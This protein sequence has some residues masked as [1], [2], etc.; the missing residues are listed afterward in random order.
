VF[1]YVIAELLSQRAVK[2]VVKAMN[3]DYTFESIQPLAK[4]A[5]VFQ[6]SPN[7]IHRHI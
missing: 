4:V 1:C 2:A 3:F 7:F 5:L 6:K